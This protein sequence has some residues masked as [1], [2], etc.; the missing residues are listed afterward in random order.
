MVITCANITE[1]LCLAYIISKCKKQKQSGL[2]GVNELKL[3]PKCKILE[4]FRDFCQH[5]F[6]IEVFSGIN[7]RTCIYFIDIQFSK[8]SPRSVK[9][10]QQ[11]PSKQKPCTCYLD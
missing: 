10:L 2:F 9:Y 6:Y 5:F 8:A 11:L 1:K 3:R 7:L 4:S